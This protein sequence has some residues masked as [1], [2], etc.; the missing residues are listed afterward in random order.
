MSYAWGSDA[1]NAT[2]I[3]RERG[4][5]VDRLLEEALKRGIDLQRDKDQLGFG[6]RIGAYMNAMTEGD[7]VAVILSAK[8]LRSPWCMTELCGIW[9]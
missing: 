7:R 3:D 6:D 9:E 8:Y 4:R 1:A 2:D 5:V